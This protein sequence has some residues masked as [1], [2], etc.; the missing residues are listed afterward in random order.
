MHIVVLNHRIKCSVEL[1]TGNF[2]AEKLAFIRNM[3]HMIVLYTA[4]RTTHV[5][6]YAVL[7]AVVNLV[8]AHDMGTYKPASP[9]NPQRF[10]NCLKLVLIPGFTLRSRPLIISSGNFLAQRNSREFRIMKHIIFDNPPARPV[11]SEHA[12]LRRGRRSPI[13]RGI[14]YFKPSNSNV[15]NMV[16]SRKEACSPYADFN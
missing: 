13:P 7:P 4:E 14:A 10:E 11:R 2:P 6:H 3:M 16:S 5:P 9:A 1:D 8:V 12:P 15:I